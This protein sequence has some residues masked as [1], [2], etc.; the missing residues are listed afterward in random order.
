M[1]EMSSTSNR[2]LV[3]SWFPDTHRRDAARSPHFPSCWISAPRSLI[4]SFPKYLGVWMLPRLSFAW[5]ALPARG[6]VLRLGV[7]AP[8]WSCSLMAGEK[9]YDAEPVGGAQRR[10]VTGWVRERLS[11]TDLPTGDN[12]YFRQDCWMSL[13]E[14]LD[15]CI[16]SVSAPRVTNT[17]GQTF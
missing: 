11:S 8:V 16:F 6:W 15:S 5:V 13:K 2:V 12:F 4:L 10:K 1:K 7:S 17:W 14:L 3:P 9:L